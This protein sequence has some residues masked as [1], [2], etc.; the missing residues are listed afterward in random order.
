MDAL[1]KSVFL[2]GPTEPESRDLL[3]KLYEAKN[4]N[5]TGMDAFIASAGQKIGQ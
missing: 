3:Q 4:K 2:K 1:A 5:T